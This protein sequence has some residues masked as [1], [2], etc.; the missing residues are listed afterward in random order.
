MLPAVPGK[1]ATRK[2]ADSPD[3]QMIRG[4]Q[5]LSEQDGLVAYLDYT[6]PGFYDFLSAGLQ[7]V[8]DGRL[9]PDAL[10]ADM[11]REYEEFLR[12]SA[13]DAG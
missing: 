11:Q 1:A 3:G 13:E 10:T 5:R 4:W 8:I 9:S 12:K 7:D 6:T 2:P